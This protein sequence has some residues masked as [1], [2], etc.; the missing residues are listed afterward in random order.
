MLD[1]E[2]VISILETV[3]FNKSILELIRNTDKLDFF[4]KDFLI[5]SSAFRKVL[6]G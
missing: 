5:D 2:K 3:N 4:V 1:K 6:G